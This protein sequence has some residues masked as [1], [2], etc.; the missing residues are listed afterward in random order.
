MKSFTLLTLFSFVALSIQGCAT[1]KQLSATGGSRA[2]GTVKMS[3]EYGPFEVP[4]LDGSQG[5]AVATHRCAAWGYTGAEPFG[6]ASK[7]CIDVS[8]G[9]CDRWQVTYEYQCTGTPPA[10]R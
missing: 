9:G 4:Q 3:F 10:S 5:E 6:G 1:P 7:R 2:D 8:G